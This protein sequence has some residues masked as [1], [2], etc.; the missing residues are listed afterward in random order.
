[1]SGIF[2]GATQVACERAAGVGGAVL[3]HRLLLLGHLQGLDR[4]LD[5]ASLL[6][7]EHDAGVDA[8]AGREALGALLGE[9]ASQLGALDEGHHVGVGDLDVETRLLDLDHLTGDDLAL[10]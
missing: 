8:L 6:V 2:A 1:M 5:L 3:R 10:L 9:I 7:E 4:D